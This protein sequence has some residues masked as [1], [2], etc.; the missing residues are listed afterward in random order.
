[1]EIEHQVK[2]QLGT[3]I[4]SRPSSRAEKKIRFAEV[5]PQNVH[6]YES[7]P[8]SPKKKPLALMSPTDVE[9]SDVPVVSLGTYKGPLLSQPTTEDLGRGAVEEG[10]PADIRRRFFPGAPAYDPSLEWIQPAKLTGSASPT[11]SVRFDL[12]GKPIPVELSSSLPTHLGLHHHAEGEHAGYTLDDLLLLSRSTVPAQRASILRVLTHVAARLVRNLAGDFS[13]GVEELRGQEHLLRRRF[14]AAAVE[15]VG[16]RGGVGAMAIELLWECLVQW[17]RDTHSLD[18]IE[19]N[20]PPGPQPVTDPNGTGPQE[21]PRSG[22]YI[23]SLPLEY[24]LPRF[25]DALGFAALPTESLSQLL[26]V[27]YR[28]AQHSNDIANTIVTTPNLIINLFRTFLLTP[29]PPT[30]SSPPP[31]PFALALLRLLTR[32][33]RSNASALAEPADSLLRFI[34]SLPT[35]SPYP[36]S[37]ANSLTAGT[38]N[39]YAALASYGMYS[40]IVTTASTQFSELHRHIISPSCRSTSL[41]LSWLGL[42][43]AWMICARDPHQTSPSHE[44]LWSQVTAWSWGPDVVH[45]R[46]QLDADSDSQL[47]SAL[48]RCLSAWLEGAQVNAVS[49]GGTER[50]LVVEVM[51][52]GFGGGPEKVVF[53]SAFRT[54]RETLADFQ[55]RDDATAENFGTLARNADILSA[56]LR[57]WVACTP[58]LSYAT[59]CLESPPFSLPF[60]QLQE[61]TGLIIRS[62]LW[63]RI[64]S[65]SSV[66]PYSQAFLRPLSSYLAQ[67]LRLFR[68]LPTSSNDLWLAQAFA[69]LGK[70]IPGDD[71]FA[72]RTLDE[73]VALL[74]PEFVVSHGL[75]EKRKL[76][77]LLVEGGFEVAMPFLK[78][79]FEPEES[80][81]IGSYYPSPQ[82]LRSSNT[83]RL[84]PTHL[85]RNHKP[86]MA[87]EYPLPLYGDWLFTPLD[88]L[89]RSG[90]SSVFKSLPPSW[91]GSEVGVVR[92]TLLLAKIARAALVHNGLQELVMGFSETVFGC[93]KVFM[94]EH[95][96]HEDS[97]REVFKDA[98]VGGL[99]EDL[100]SPFSANGSELKV[101]RPHL[102]TGGKSKEEDLESIAIR[103]LG[104]GTPFYQYYTDFVHLYDAISFGHP[105]FSKLLLVP[106]SMDYP[107]D[108]R[109][110]VWGDYCQ[111]LRSVRTRTVNVLLSSPFQFSSYLW[112]VERDP[113]VVGYF[114]RALF[115]TGALA[116][117][118]F[119]RFVAVHHIA[120]GI[121]EDLAC[122]PGANVERGG[123]I[124]EWDR[125]KATQMLKAVV[126]QGP[127]ELMREV[128]TYKQNSEE[129]QPLLLPPHCFERNSL[130]RGVD[131]WSVGWEMRRLEFVGCVGGGS[132]VEK[133]RQL[134]EPTEL[135]TM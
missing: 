110:F 64:Y 30:S 112:P 119:L 53:T 133:L 70:Q 66:P 62:P 54:L 100:L 44:I 103:F 132:L 10:T 49:G 63:S 43:E 15:A 36:L 82:S 58:P 17:D 4:I 59:N 26:E 123:E 25:S 16:E 73:I 113:H 12:D 109:K 13:S 56:A 23:T 60:P 105:A 130:S 52:Q 27:L 78:D 76:D 121:W 46:D 34:T 85:V 108:Y 83:Q 126:E 42:L 134:I 90:T 3:P 14:L 21:L 57:L 55:D 88:H 95:E 38:L 127:P 48:W 107:V 81:R 94:L 39:F 80:A 102:R 125:E 37:L 67:H 117:D 118:G 20:L 128:V 91:D 22:D 7:A 28:L 50:S 114:M 131:E 116:I 98:I 40:H 45:F 61:L 75:L 77:I 29:I 111:V 92:V 33:S 74:N 129:G 18:S 135:T 101:S 96:Q 104:S 69:I 106:T 86:S 79:A 51:R 87:R 97:G 32:A 99:L 71:D 47:W 1:M 72:R 31:N 89:L 41:R 124:G 6:V 2:S 84:P 8:S 122:F 120:S 115:K 35:T 65:D 68:R 5:V 93:M 11:S 24:L 19:L 9:P